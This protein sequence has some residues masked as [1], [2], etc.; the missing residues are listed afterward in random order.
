[1]RLELATLFSLRLSL[2]DHHKFLTHSDNLNPTLLSTS[3]ICSLLTLSSAE[4]TLSCRRGAHAQCCWHYLYRE[5]GGCLY[6]IIQWKTYTSVLQAKNWATEPLRSKCALYRRQWYPL[7]Q[8]KMH[9]HVDCPWHFCISSSSSS[10]DAVAHKRWGVWN[11]FN[12]RTA[13]LSTHCFL[14]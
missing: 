13:R 8:A 12:H 2:N 7:I 1:M 4:P 5:G 14:L 9:Q 3:S 10:P 6:I 11:W